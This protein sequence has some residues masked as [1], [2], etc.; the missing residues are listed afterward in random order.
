M[1]NLKKEKKRKNSPL[2][3]QKLKQ[4]L[5]N[6]RIDVLKFNHQVF[7]KNENLTIDELLK[8]SFA[9]TFLYWIDISNAQREEIIQISQKFNFHNLITEDIIYTSHRPKYSEVNESHFLISKMLFFDKVEK[10]IDVEQISFITSKNMLFTFQEESKRDDFETVREK[11]QNKESKLRTTNFSLDYLLYLMLNEII[12]NYYKITDSFSEELEFIDANILENSSINFEHLNN[13][14]K[15]ILLL[16]RIIFPMREVINGIL[17]SEDHFFKEI[18]YKYYKD[19]SENINTNLETIDTFRE[20]LFGFQELYIN[21]I[22]LRMNEVMKTLA[23]ITSFMAPA[24]VIGGIF[25]MNFDIIPYQHHKWGFYGTV[26]IMLF[27]PIL[28]MVWFKKR[29]WF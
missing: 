21:N 26:F 27:I 11:I 10:T 24:T 9:N 19:L 28:M 5:G 4:N 17:K 18:N 2:H 25:G 12:I 7:E 8:Y 22:N 23:I 29:K 15:E 6:L 20:M 14:R 3:P 16:K 1:N 13:I